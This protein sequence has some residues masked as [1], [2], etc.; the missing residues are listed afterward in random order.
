MQTIGYMASIHT[1]TNHPASYT[2]SHSSLQPASTI[3]WL[4]PTEFSKIHL[5]KFAPCSGKSSLM[6]H[7][8]FRRPSKLGSLGG[9]V[10]ARHRKD[11]QQTRA[12]VHEGACTIDPLWLL[13]V[14]LESNLLSSDY[15][16]ALSRRQGG[17]EA[18]GSRLWQGRRTDVFTPAT[19]A[20]GRSSGA[21]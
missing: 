19:A 10:G 5:L 4:T 15:R 1:P 14:S 7:F 12:G 13:A 17:K 16:P 8:T 6:V 20:T 18:S 2:P 21:I 11:Q 3:L 9:A